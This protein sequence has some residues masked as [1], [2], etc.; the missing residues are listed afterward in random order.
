MYNDVSSSLSELFLA[1]VSF[2][3]FPPPF[4]AFQ[5]TMTSYVYVLDEVICAVII[6]DMCIM[7][8]RKPGTY[9]IVTMLRVFLW[10]LIREAGI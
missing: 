10:F 7:S 6:A 9:T 4:H 3:K 2:P 1:W 5:Y 8:Q